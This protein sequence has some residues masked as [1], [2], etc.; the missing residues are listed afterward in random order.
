MAYVVVIP[1][2]SEESFS[3]LRVMWIENEPI[4]SLASN[5]PLLSSPHRSDRTQFSYFKL[6]SFLRHGKGLGV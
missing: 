5:S 4:L 2:N 6:Y 1:S 3:I